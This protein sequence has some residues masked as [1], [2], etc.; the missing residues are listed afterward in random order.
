MQD[1]GFVHYWWRHDYQSAAEWFRRGS[2]VTGAPVWMKSLAA[3]TLAQ[4]GDRRS[5]RLMWEA[6]RD[7]AEIE[8][9]RHD[10]ERHLAQLQA[11]DDIDALQVIVNRVSSLHGATVLDWGPVVRAAGW[12]GIPLD[13]SGTPYE[14]DRA[15]RVQLSPS[16]RLWPIPAEPQ[17]TGSRQ[18]PP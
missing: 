8:W 16:S 3:T 15:G 14:I 17:G 9:F 12:R 11:L 1:I 5:S 13:P 2:E 7:S 6:I 18:T 10:A 4:G